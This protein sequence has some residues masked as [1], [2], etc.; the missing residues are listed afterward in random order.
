MHPKCD[1]T[2]QNITVTCNLVREIAVFMSRAAEWRWQRYGKETLWGDN[3]VREV[4]EQKDWARPPPALSHRA[5]LDNDLRWRC[6]VCLTTAKDL[7]SLRSVQCVDRSLTV[8]SH[9]LRVAGNFVFCDRCGLY[10]SVRCRGLKTACQPPKCPSQHKRLSNL[11]Q[12]R[13]PVHGYLV[14]SVASYDFCEEWRLLDSL[15]QSL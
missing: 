4:L 7:A 14:G 9:K 8:E 5:V 13:H 2:L 11:R 15:A 3:A 6:T 10:S 1:V 12:G